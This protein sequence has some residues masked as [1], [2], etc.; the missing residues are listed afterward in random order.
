MNNKKHLHLKISSTTLLL[1]FFINCPAQ[2]IDAVLNFADSL[3]KEQKYSLALY[4]YK[5]AYFFS[6]NEKKQVLSIQIVNSYLALKDYR[7]AKTYCDS[8]IYYSQTD[9]LKTACQLQKIVIYLLEN[10]FDYALLK[11]DEIKTDSNSYFQTRKSLLQGISNLGIEQ[12][13]K[14][15]QFLNTAL[16]PTDSVK[17]KLLKKLFEETKKLKKPSPTLAT[18]M[19]IVL[20]GSGQIYSGKYASGLNSLLLLGGLTCIGVYSPALNVLIAPMFS[21]YYMGGILHANQFAN[22][23]K[24]LKQAGFANE[25]LT[26]FPENTDLK[27]IFSVKLNEMNFHKHILDSDAEIPL[28]ISASFMAYKK[29]FS[30]QDVD[31]CVFSPSCSVYMM[32]SVKKNGLFTGF[33][34]GL[35]RLMRCHAFVHKNDYNYYKNTVKYNDPN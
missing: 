11:L 22:E 8:A 13:D 30:S 15:F 27:P 14:A 4:E 19:S 6:E 32:E 29:Y 21:R 28:L 24:K 18:L 17:Q 35:D 33:L 25:V 12:Y 34:D 2:V 5:R 20:P 16:N 10:N 31:A 3:Y 23:R 9:S 7:T 1:L 26:L